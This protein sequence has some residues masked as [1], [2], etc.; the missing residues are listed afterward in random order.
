LVYSTE[1]DHYSRRAYF[2]VQ[3]YNS[4]GCL[5]DGRLRG[6]DTVIFCLSQTHK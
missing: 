6:L 5:K 1:Q 4:T 3:N 2:C